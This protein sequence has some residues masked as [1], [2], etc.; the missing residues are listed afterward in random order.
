[1]G[2]NIGDEVPEFEL[3]DQDGQLFNISKYLGKHH[4]I[5]YFYPRDESPGCTTEA[6]TFRDNIEKFDDLN[7]K[8]IGISKDSSSRHNSF[9]KH[10]KLPFT[11]LSD[12][13]NK[14]RQLFGVKPAIP[15]LIQGRKTYII[16]TEGKV[17]HMFEYQYQPRKHVLKSLLALEE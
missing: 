7:C 6:C 12:R 9:S 8:I 3:K 11:L 1:M 15:G 2:L 14:V 13:Q 5:V 17:S 10:Y 16:N 4:I